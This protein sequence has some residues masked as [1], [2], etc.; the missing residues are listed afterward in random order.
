MSILVIAML[1]LY[2][3]VYII[4]RRKPKFRLSL[5]TA[6]VLSVLFTSMVL[7]TGTFWICAGILGQWSIKTYYT[8]EQARDS[9]SHR[10]N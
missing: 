7:M 3:A 8:D 4:F 9:E 10:T 5:K 6:A 1:P 2:G